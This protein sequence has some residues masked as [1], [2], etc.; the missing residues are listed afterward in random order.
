M[1][2][3]GEALMLS[4]HTH[5]MRFILLYLLVALLL[6]NTRG[7]ARPHVIHVVRQIDMMKFLPISKEEGRFDTHK[8]KQA[9]ESVV[10]SD[11][12]SNGRHGADR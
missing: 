8:H 2:T 7:E 12:Q 1:P 4:A 6:T 3:H 10:S 11:T 9:T 5:V